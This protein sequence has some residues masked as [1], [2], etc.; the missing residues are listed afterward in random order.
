MQVNL[1]GLLSLRANNMFQCLPLHD[2]EVGEERHSAIIIRIHV[3]NELNNV[4]NECITF[5]YK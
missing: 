3:H 4:Q 2:E 5:L 1:I